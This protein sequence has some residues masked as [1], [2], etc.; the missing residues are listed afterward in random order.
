MDLALVLSLLVVM[1]IAALGTI[2][3]MA[4]VI[5]SQR[6]AILRWKEAWPRFGYNALSRVLNETKN[7]FKAT[8]SEEQ[9]V[10]VAKLSL[11]TL[12]L[13]DN[14]VGEFKLNRAALTERLEKTLNDMEEIRDAL[15]RPDVI[16]HEE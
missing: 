14:V 2:L 5:A 4:Y 1:L 15:I 3:Y 8:F 7:R 13:P 16:P 9:C 11:R 6:L 12:G 10:F